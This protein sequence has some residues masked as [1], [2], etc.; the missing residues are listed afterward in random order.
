MESR[1]INRSSWDSGSSWVPAE[2]TG[3]WVAMT[4]KGW[5]RGRL[6]LSTVTWPSS[7]ASSRALWVLALVRLISSAKNKLHST[8]PGR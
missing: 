7:M 8:A 2:P 5:G 6:M 1:I 3:F 4:V